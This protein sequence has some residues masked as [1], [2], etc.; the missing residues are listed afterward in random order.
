MLPSSPAAQWATP[1]ARLPQ[2]ASVTELPL[3][4]LL[5]LL[6]PL[7][8]HLLCLDIC[9]HLAPPTG[10]GAQPPGCNVRA[11]Q[12]ARAG[13]W[14]AAQ[15]IV[16]LAEHTSAGLI[17][18]QQTCARSAAAGRQQAPRGGRRWLALAAPS[19]WAARP[20]H[21]AASALP[22]QLRLV[23]LPAGP[24]PPAGKRCGA[25]RRQAPGP[26]FRPV[27]APG[28]QQ[29]RDAWYACRAPA[30]LVRC[31]SPREAG[32]PHCGCA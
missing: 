18:T 31:A 15:C 5:P 10:G 23:M 12:C 11:R 4:L 25:L 21:V 8:L 17:R 29:R 14:G 20:R 27:Q 9:H 6:P 24:E 1:A 28:M 13:T 7:M 16:Q 19:C 32:L 3:L 2:A 30:Y 22:M 26:A